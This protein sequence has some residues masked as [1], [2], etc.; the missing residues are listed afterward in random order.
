MG[1]R[2]RRSLREGQHFLPTLS[3]VNRSAGWRAARRMSKSWLITSRSL[4][5]ISRIRM[6]LCL[7]MSQS[8]MLDKTRTCA[9]QVLFRHRESAEDDH[10]FGAIVHST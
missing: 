7:L 1:G 3:T 9:T 2:L 4:R 10:I 8:H 6:D 5:L